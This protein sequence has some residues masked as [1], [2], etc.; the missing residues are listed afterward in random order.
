[1]ATRSEALGRLEGLIA[2]LGKDLQK[3]PQCGDD[4]YL[5][6]ACPAPARRDQKDYNSSLLR[7][8]WFY[9]DYLGGGPEE[10]LCADER[11]LEMTKE[12]YSQLPEDHIVETLN[13]I[14]FQLFRQPLRRRLGSH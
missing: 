14:N 11:V 7:A 2:A 4:G 12:Q 3:K 8:G 9:I 1:M 5:D 10:V 6:Q 13:H